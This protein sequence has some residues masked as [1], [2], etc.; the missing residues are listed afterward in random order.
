MWNASLESA[1]GASTEIDWQSKIENTICKT[2]LE[3][4]LGYK[5]GNQ[6][7]EADVKRNVEKQRWE[8]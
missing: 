2:M 6:T 1:G 5:D 8:T 4:R 3:S 7:L